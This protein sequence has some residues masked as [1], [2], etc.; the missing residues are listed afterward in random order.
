MIP[1]RRV[2]IRQFVSGSKEVGSFSYLSSATSVLDVEM[3]IRG[4]AERNNILFDVSDFVDDNLLLLLLRK[5]LDDIHYIFAV[6]NDFTS[7]AE[8]SETVG[9]SEFIGG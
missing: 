2:R 1:V 9:W 5:K 8:V 6:D 3:E 7:Q 4:W